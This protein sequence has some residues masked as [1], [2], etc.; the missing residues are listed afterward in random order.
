MKTIFLLSILLTGQIFAQATTVS[1]I[2]LIANPEKYDGKVVRFEG[3]ANI[4]FE[5]N[6]IF[7]SREHRKA[8]VQ[9]FAIWMDL[10]DELAKGRKWL[11]GKYCIV[12]GKFHAADRGHMGLYMGSLSDITMFNA[13][14]PIN[15]DEAAKLQKEAE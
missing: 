3:V 12:E 10:S 5:G 4:E 14:E 7:L 8:R 2:Q 15:P 11:N 1:I 9:S 13:R 6:G